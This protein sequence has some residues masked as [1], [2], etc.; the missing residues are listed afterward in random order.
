MFRTESVDTFVTHLHTMLH[1]PT[2]HRF[3]TANKPEFNT[4]FARQPCGFGIYKNYFKYFVYSSK[5]SYHT[6]F[7]DSESGA[8]LCHSSLITFLL[9][10][11]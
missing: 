11:N 10:T 4:D 9:A 2:L 8:M 7:N 6:K 3:V 5:I 1:M